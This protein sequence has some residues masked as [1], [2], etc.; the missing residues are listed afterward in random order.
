VSGCWLAGFDG[1]SI[2]NGSEL[3]NGLRMPCSKARNH[4]ERLTALSYPVTIQPAV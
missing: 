4:I 1:D 2:T 3:R